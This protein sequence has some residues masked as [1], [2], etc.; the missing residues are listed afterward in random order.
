[1]VRTR[2]SMSQR[3][4]AANSPHRRL[5]INREE[6]E[7]L[8]PRAD[9]AGQGGDLAGVLER[10]ALVNCQGTPSARR[11][12]RPWLG[13]SPS[14]QE[15]PRGVRNG[16]RTRCPLKDDPISTRSFPAAGTIRVLPSA[17]RLAVWRTRPKGGTGTRTGFMTIAGCQR[18]PTKLVR[19]GQA[20]TYDDP[21][22]LPLPD[23]LEPA[24]SAGNEPAS[25]LDLRRAEEACD[26]QPFS[27]DKARRTVIECLGSTT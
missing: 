9:R 15:S 19:D 20:E 4:S 22:D 26:Q 6:D 14:A 8:V 1:M 5:P 25:G 16:P 18:A 3:R 17:T 23:G 10:L 13:F 11:A 24:N 12:V 7:R 21:P 27:T 2:R